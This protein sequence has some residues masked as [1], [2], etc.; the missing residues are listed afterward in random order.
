MSTAGLIAAAGLS[1]RMGRPKALLPLGS[2]GCAFVWHL[3]TVFVEAGLKPLIVTIPEGDVG[4]AIAAVLKPLA[5]NPANQLLCVP[6]DDPGL[7]LTGSVRT[8]LVRASTATGLVMTPVDAPHASAA[9]IAALRRGLLTTTAEAVV[10]VVGSSRAHPVAFRKTCWRRLSACAVLGGPRGLLD[11]LA[12][13]G[14]LHQVPWGDWRVLQ[15]I[16]TPED[17]ERAFGCPL[18]ARA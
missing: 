15:D 6:N 18:V 10:P 9:L 12:A 7:G 4:D 14:G 2:A 17:W 16:N 8:A 3:A 11:E 1:A 13:E 5:Q